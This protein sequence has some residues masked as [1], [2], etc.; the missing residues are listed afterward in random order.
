MPITIKGTIR[1]AYRE[2]PSFDVE[3]EG[4]VGLTELL[5]RL[6]NGEGL[7][8][9]NG[10]NI[11]VNTIKLGGTLIEET[12]I[13]NTNQL[14]KI[15]QDVANNKAYI[16]QDNAGKTFIVH[17]EDATFL[18]YIAVSKTGFGVQVENKST[19]ISSKIDLSA[20]QAEFNISDTSTGDFL[21]GFILQET[22]LQAYGVRTYANTGAAQADSTFEVG[23]IYRLNGDSVLRIK[24]T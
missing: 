21:C 18:S 11:D 15:G 20:T 5:Q 3:G 22:Q 8:A 17:H 6:S 19:E 9:D 7:E 10:I 16:L 1:G 14:L 2:E 4:L 23:G 12:T 13:T 24:T